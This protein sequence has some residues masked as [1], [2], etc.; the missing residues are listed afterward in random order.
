ML[1]SGPI[2]TE[3]NSDLA[4]VVGLIA[5]DGCL[6]NDGRHI[7]ITSKDEEILLYIRKILNLGNKIGKKAR[8]GE[9]EKKYFVL[10][11]E[12]VAFYKFLL[13]VGLTPAKS[14]TMTRLTIP[15]EYFAS[16]LRGCIDGD[17]SIGTFTHPESTHPQLRLSLCSASISFLNWIKRDIQSSFSTTGGWIDTSD[18][19][20]CSILRYGIADSIIILNEL[21]CDGSDYFLKRKY[22]IW[23]Q[24]KA[25]VA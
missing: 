12:S 19:N 4:Y 13:S 11:F 10:Q 7:G 22:R 14:K 15:K 3:W 2:S 18:A 9:Q 25:G 20:G 23:E 16:F 1:R 8:G 5:S 17:G 21:Y 24:Y 6:Y